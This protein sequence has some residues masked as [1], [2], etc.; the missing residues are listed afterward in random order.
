LNRDEAPPAVR[1]K[2]ID[3]GLRLRVGPMTLIAGGFEIEKP[4]YGLDNGNIFRELGAIRHR[5]LEA[6]LA[7]S[8]VEG[9]TLVVGGVLLDAKLAG[10]EVASGVIGRRPVGVPSRTLSGNIEWR[11]PQWEAFSVDLSA[12]H[13]GPTYT[14]V[15]NAVRVGSYTT[16]NMGVRY[17]F[18]L[19]GAPAVLRLKAT[20][21]FNT[22]AWDV[23]GNN[24]FTYIQSRQLIARFTIDLW[25]STSVGRAADPSD[26]G[27]VRSL[28][29]VVRGIAEI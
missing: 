8:P 12:E 27:G 9:W 4:Y 23:Y 2:Q 18:P 19:Q 17:R 3:A 16:M 20:N 26:V 1:T 14:D 22:C 15:A 10:D 5:G 24:A 7:G 21:L 13:R 25:G 28:P 29:S 11:P 6:S